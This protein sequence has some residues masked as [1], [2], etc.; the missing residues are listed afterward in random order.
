MSSITH[1]RSCR[2]PVQTFN[3]GRPGIIVR[4]RISSR[5]KKN[6]VHAGMGLF[7]QANGS[8]YIEQGNTKALAVVYGPHEVRLLLN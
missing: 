3:D 1:V 4:P 5:L 8:A 2:T 6:W 7:T